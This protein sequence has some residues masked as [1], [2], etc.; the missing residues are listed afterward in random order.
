M[1]W[2]FSTFFLE[3]RFQ[4]HPDLAMLQKYQ[5]LS[6]QSF[7]HNSTYM[8]SFD[9]TP[10]LSFEPRFRMFIITGYESKSKRLQSL[11]SLFIWCDLS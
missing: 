11:E 8:P 10:T 5:S 1:K 2:L 9:L 6:N 3:S 4:N 7:K